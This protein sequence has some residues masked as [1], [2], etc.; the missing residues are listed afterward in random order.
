MS[1]ALHSN[2]THKLEPWEEELFVFNGGFVS[3]TLVNWHPTRVAGQ[4]AGVRS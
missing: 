1:E 3:N 2:N 4:Q